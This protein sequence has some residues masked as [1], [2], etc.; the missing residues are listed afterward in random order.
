MKLVLSRHGESLWNKENKFTGW[1]DIELT[2]TGVNQAK[3]KGKF[4]L[5]RKYNFDIAYTSV[6]KRANDTLKYILEEMNIKIP[7][8]YNYQLNERHYGV[9]QGLNKKETTEKFGEE[10]VKKWRRSV[11]ERP[12]LIDKNNPMFPGKDPKY[13]NIPI[14]KLPLG[15]NLLDTIKR[16][17]EYFDATIKEELL[18]KNIL[19]VAHGNS[20]RALIKKLENISNE[21]IMNIE[22]SF[23][24]LIVY[25]FD[26]NLKIINKEIL[27]IET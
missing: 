4:L 6:L 9:L 5:E 2:E 21:E 10:Q 17:G 7:I 15:E 19:I 14:E 11:D 20:I 12:P 22:I 24:E 26:E 16:V 27:K 13:K 3:A 23:D 1:V 8:I 25:D 18:K